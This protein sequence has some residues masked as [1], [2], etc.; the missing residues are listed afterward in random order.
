MA[1]TSAQT[2]L[3]AVDA[4]LGQ[5]LP[6]L[7]AFRGSTFDI[8]QGTCAPRNSARQGSSSN[9]AFPGTRPSCLY[10][11]RITWTSPG[12]ALRLVGDKATMAA[13]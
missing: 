4:L 10:D 9:A 3:G 7:D 6:T 11:A 12:E 8:R 2:K 1:T 13:S 5:I